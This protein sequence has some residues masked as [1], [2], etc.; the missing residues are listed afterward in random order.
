MCY[1]IVS[2]TLTL[3]QVFQRAVLKGSMP[4]P[5]NKDSSQLQIRDIRTVTF[6]L[7]QIVLI[8]SLYEG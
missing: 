5:M 7:M 2:V 6:E 3:L 4:S 1:R 8:E